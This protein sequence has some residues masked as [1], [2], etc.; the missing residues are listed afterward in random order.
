[1]TNTQTPKLSK[2]DREALFRA[3]RYR[4]RQDQNAAFGHDPGVH[5]IESE[6]E[7]KAG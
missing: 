7:D 4:I 1:M 6:K 2:A 3:E 5:F